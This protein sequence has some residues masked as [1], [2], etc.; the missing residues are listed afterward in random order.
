MS[1][2][3]KML[4]RRGDADP[5]RR[6]RRGGRAQRGHRV[7]GHAVV[8]LIN[9]IDIFSQAVYGTHQHA[10]LRRST[11]YQARAKAGQPIILFRSQRTP[12]RR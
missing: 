12:T 3:S 5:G 4:R 10:E 6:H 1:I 9:C 2:K 11:C 7:G 8:R